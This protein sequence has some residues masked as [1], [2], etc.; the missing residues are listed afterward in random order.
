MIKPYP[1]VLKPSYMHYVWGG[2]RISNIFNRYVENPLNAESW[3]ASD[4]EEGMSFIENGP[5]K[6]K[7][8]RDILLHYPDFVTLSPLIRFPLLIKLIDAD[9][10]LSIQVHP[11]DQNAF[12]FGG[13]AKSEMWHILQADPES[14]IYL[15]LKKRLSDAEIEKAIEEETLEQHMN[16]IPVKEGQTFYIPGGLLHS[17]GKGCL[18]YEVQQNSNTTYRLYDWGRKDE[19]GKSR[20]LHVEKGLQVMLK[21]QQIVAHKLPKI[22]TSK[23]GVSHLHL[24]KCPY[25]EFNKYEITHPL[26]LQTENRF[27][28][29]FIAEGNVILENENEKFILKKGQTYMIPPKCSRL[30]VIPSS[31]QVTLLE[32]L[33]CS[34]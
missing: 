32:T 16:E 18:I 13:E 5:L 27:R 15:G 29:H 22:L 11:N 9:K 8:L 1:L 17:I 23:E 4:R 6:G 24:L 14:R 3:E 26:S 21:D 19:M 30:K 33:P 12:L 28:V 25:F 7:S 2:R 20:P 31:H 34:R 10:P